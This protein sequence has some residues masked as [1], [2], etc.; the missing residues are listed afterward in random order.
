M[1]ESG[2]IRFCLESSVH[3]SELCR[4]GFLF[5]VLFCQWNADGKSADFL[6]KILTQKMKNGGNGRKREKYRAVTE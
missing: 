2:Q 5:Q 1:K 4:K 3:R 6:E